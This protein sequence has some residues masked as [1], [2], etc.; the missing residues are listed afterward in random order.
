MC[1]TFF[2]FHHHNTNYKYSGIYNKNINDNFS[3]EYFS[4]GLHPKDIDDNWKEQLEKIYKIAKNNNCLLIGE[5]G[6]DSRISISKENQ[7]KIFKEHIYIAETLNK[8]IIIHCVRCFDE[9]ISLCK[10]VKVP[11]IIHGFNKRE[12][13]A[14]TLINNGFLLSFGHSII[15]NISLQ[16]TFIKIP[17]ELFLLETDSSGISIEEI[18]NKA[19]ILRNISINKLQNIIHNNLN[20]L[21]GWKITTIG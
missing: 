3:S 7:I 20:N 5:C 10:K 8:P 9:I 13:I 21:L 17:K 6:L 4:A 14:K 1:K 16:N 15:N 19:S 11:K 12:N 18:Y 2:D